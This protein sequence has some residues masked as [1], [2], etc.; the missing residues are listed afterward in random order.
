MAGMRYRGSRRLPQSSLAAV[1]QASLQT[2]QRTNSFNGAIV[3]RRVHIVER[4]PIRRPLRTTPTRAAA[5]T[6][7]RIKN[8]IP[9]LVEKGLISKELAEKLLKEMDDIL[10]KYR[11]ELLSNEE[12]MRFLYSANRFLMSQ[13]KQ[14]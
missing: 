8:M 6:A 10:H 3:N 4:P 11:N 12:A 1:A 2:A 14:K 9:R 13:R 7:I 5:N